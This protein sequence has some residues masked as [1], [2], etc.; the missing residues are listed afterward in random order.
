MARFFRKIVKKL[1]PILS[2]EPNHALQGEIGAKNDLYGF[3]AGDEG[4]EPPNAGTRTRCL[5]T[6]RI[7]KERGK[8]KFYFLFLSDAGDYFAKQNLPQE[9]KIKKTCSLYLSDTGNNLAKQIFP[10]PIITQILVKQV[11]YF[12]TTL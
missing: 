7:P 3:M 5:T 6:W 12:L 1:A 4:F 9:T 10:Q 11:I 8:R 2:K